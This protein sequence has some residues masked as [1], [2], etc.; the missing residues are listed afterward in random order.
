[1]SHHRGAI[2]RFIAAM[3]LATLV[4]L[5][6]A[7]LASAHEHRHVAD[8]KYEMVVG[9]LTEPAVQNQVNGLDLRVAMHDE[10]AGEDDEGIPVEGLQNTLQAEVTFGGQTR[11]LELEPAF[12]APGRYRAYFIP[13]A[14][15]A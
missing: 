14:P 11:Q 7:G 10:H 15:G 2:R 1:M 3:S 8:D 9:F 5:L 4:T 6:T 13:T 12:N